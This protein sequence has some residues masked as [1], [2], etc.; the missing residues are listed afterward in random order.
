MHFIAHLFGWNHGR[1]IT[2]IDADGVLWV[3]FEC[4]KC[5]KISGIHKT[6]Y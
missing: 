6:Q 3:G 5:G 4:S 1:A 2:Q